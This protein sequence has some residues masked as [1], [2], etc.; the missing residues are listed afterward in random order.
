M[1]QTVLSHLSEGVRTVRLNR[2]D[3]LNAINPTL[4]ADLKAALDT[5]DAD[6]ETKVVVLRGEGRAFC[7]GDDLKEFDQQ[8]GTEAETRAYIESIQDI[9]R[10]I[11]LGDKM[12]VGAIHGWAVGGGLEWMIN[13]DLAI[14]AEGTRCFFPEV[15]LGLFVTGGVTRLLPA[16]VGLTKAREMILFGERFDA[17][18]ALDMGLAWKVVPEARLVAE[19]EATARRIAA[20]PGHAVSALKQVLARAPGS[21]L[22]A[23][24]ALETEATLRGFLDPETAQIIA[25]FG[26]E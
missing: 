19:A 5:A 6:P 12:V 16:M 4:L 23:A 8:A 13:C 18:Q 25:R 21:G 22:E 2:P 11:V 17:S 1:N 10:A 20:L 3:R 24:M 26:K 9:T 14:L 7:A 15:S